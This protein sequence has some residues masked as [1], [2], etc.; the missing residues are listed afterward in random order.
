MKII[1]FIY[2]LIVFQYTYPFCIRYLGFPDIKFLY[3]NIIL[4]GFFFFSWFMYPAQN[5]SKNHSQSKP[6]RVLSKYKKMFLLL[7]F[8]FVFSSI[9]NSSHWFVI[10]KYAIEYYFPYILLFLII[11]RIKL[12]N[13]EEIKL[14][15]LC[16]NI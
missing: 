8:M 11:T 3:I 13:E 14:I 12:T 1:N 16:R 9:I 15:K 4:T 2:F 10:T 7:F 6:F 5:H